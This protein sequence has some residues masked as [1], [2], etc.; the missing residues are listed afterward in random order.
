MQLKHICEDD[1]KALDAIDQVPVGG[2]GATEGNQNASK[3][4]DDNITLRLPD[5]KPKP[6]TGTSNTYAL[7]KLRKDRTDL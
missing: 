3:T 1:T 7:R 4:K 6:E 2:W 5:P